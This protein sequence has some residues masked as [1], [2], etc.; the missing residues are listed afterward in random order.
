[1]YYK[2]NKVE[3][4][5]AYLFFLF[6]TAQILS[7]N[8]NSRTIY[9][10]LLIAIF[11]PF[12]WS[13]I[14]NKY[15]I[16]IKI[17]YEYILVFFMLILIAIL[18]HIETSIKLVINLFEV[19]Y[20]FYLI[21]KNLWKLNIF[22]V[23]SIIVAIMQFVLLF[24]NYEWAMMISSTNISKMIWGEY[25]TGTFA[26]YYTLFF[27]PRVS[28]LSREAGF[29]ASFIVSILFYYYLRKEIK[30]RFLIKI[31]LIIGYILSFSK[32]SIVIFFLIIINKIKKLVNYIPYFFIIIFW[33]SIIAYIVYN[34]INYLIYNETFLHRFG[35]Y[36]SIFDMNIVEFLLGV[37]H[38]NIITSYPAQMMENVMG[39]SIFAGLSGFIIHNG[40]ISAVCFFIIL[41]ILNV[42]TTGIIIL[43][44]LTINVQLDTNQNF[45]VLAYFIVFKYY[46]LQNT[47][48]LNIYIEFFKR[49]STDINK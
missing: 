34:N 43:L 39:F 37:E 5:L 35:G 42:S 31:M 1:M 2:Y 30:N 4:I 40:F 12:F 25:A 20:L 48:R 16:E 27:I 23:I 7:P 13:W 17:K 11:N 47:R 49:R 9:M 3:S 22:I 46:C 28:G 14:K 29:F 44:L 21:D 19:L 38:I 26:N 8:I 10:E 24:I 15:F 41:Y 18:G 33:F 6:F 32:M 36:F 45:V